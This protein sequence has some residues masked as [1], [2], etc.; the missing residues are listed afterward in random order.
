MTLDRIAALEKALAA[1]RKLALRA[2][3]PSDAEEDEDLEPRTP[4][5]TTADRQET[6]LRPS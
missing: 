3:P 2:P 6:P 1:A 4:T 5:T